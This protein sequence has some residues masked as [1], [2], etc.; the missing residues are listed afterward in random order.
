LRK[1]IK[2]RPFQILTLFLFLAW[3]NFSFS[4]ISENEIRSRL[5]SS[6]EESL[7][8]ESSSLLQE[9]YYYLSEII[10][11]HLLELQPNSCNYNYRKGFVLLDV[12]LNAREAL[13]YF[14]KA[15]NDVDKNYDMYSVSEKSAPTDVLY[16][17]GRC[18][19]LNENYDSAIF[20]Y[21]RFTNE[22][23]PKSNLVSESKLRIEQCE[24]AKQLKI[25]KTNH[26]IF[27]VGPII[28]TSNPEISPVISTDGAIL[29]FTSNRKWENQEM[30]ELKDPLLNNFPQDIYSIEIADIDNEKPNTLTKLSFCEILENE[31]IVSLSSD[32][33]QMYLYDAL[34]ENGAISISNLDQGNYTSSRKSN[35]KELNSKYWETNCHISLDGKKLFFVSNRPGGFGGRD[36]YCMEKDDKNVWKKPYN[37]GPGVNSEFDE[38]APFLASDGQTL[39]FASNGLK[40]SGEFD[41]FYSK[42]Q[43]GVWITSVNMGYP[44]NS[45]Y[46]DAFFT[47]TSDGRYGFLS[48]NRDGGFGQFDIYR[49]EMGSILNQTALLSGFIKTSD[50]SKLPENIKAILQCI[51]CDAKNTV[52]LTPRLRDGN[53]LT[54]LEPCK[55]YKLGFQ[56]ADQI[57]EIYTTSFSTDCALNYNVIQKNVIYDI[58]K[59]RIVP[60]LSYQHIIKVLDSKTG[61]LLEG[62][63]CEFSINNEI[64]SLVINGSHLNSRIRQLVY[65]DTLSFKIKLSKRGYLTQEFNFSEQVLD[66]DSVTSIFILEPSE[67]GIDLASTLHLNPIYFDLNKFSIRKDAQLELDKIVK[68]MNDNPEISVELASHTDCRGTSSYNLALSEK[69]AKASAS[70][71]QERISNPERIY[72]KGY[73]ETQLLNHCECEDKVKSKCTD[74]EHQKNRRTEFR[75]IKN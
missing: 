70:Y 33:R 53:I 58:F 68:I 69:R 21:K 75:I 5:T 24:F 23:N 67:I 59:K 20:Y 26:S 29:Y 19:Q 50:G 6:S 36:I 35:I 7:L 43:N 39:F 37:L 32:E 71:I 18:Y 22:S 45:P 30:E 1:I 48:S 11:D 54:L 65:G 44:V 52:Y 51:D 8:I 62:V 63:N 14:L 4:Q 13:P 55:S 27:N 15:S 73:G 46:D 2:T 17:I 42:F 40:S 56:T 28:N 38:D 49:I 74:N 60:E 61:E 34:S 3:N 9:N 16:H 12:K 57:T 66:N 41:I 31:A 25:E 72:G 47:L 10:I 64:D